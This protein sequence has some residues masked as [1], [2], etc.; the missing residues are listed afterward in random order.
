MSDEDD[1]HSSDICRTLARPNQPES[2]VTLMGEHYV[3]PSISSSNMG[4]LGEIVLTR[5]SRGLSKT[6]NKEV[7]YM[8]IQLKLKSKIQELEYGLIVTLTSALI[9]LSSRLLLRLKTKECDR[10]TENEKYWRTLYMDTMKSSSTNGNQSHRRPRSPSPI[11]F[12]SS[13]GAST[14]GR[15]P[16]SKKRRMEHYHSDHRYNPLAALLPNGTNPEVSEPEDDRDELVVQ[17]WH[18]TQF[19]SKNISAPEPHGIDAT[20]QPCARKYS[21]FEDGT[22]RSISKSQLDQFRS[23]MTTVFVTL[24]NDHRNLIK[25]FWRELSKGF[26]DAFWKELRIKFPFLRYCNNNWKGQKF[27][28]DHYRRWYVSSIEKGQD[29]SAGPKLEGDAEDVSTSPIERHKRV[30]TKLRPPPSFAVEIIRPFLGKTGTTSSQNHQDHSP[31]SPSP[32][33]RT[34]SGSPPSALH[35]SNIPSTLLPSDLGNPPVTTLDSP[36]GLP[37]EESALQ[38][39]LVAPLM[40]F[41]DSNTHQ[42]QEHS[43]MPSTLP[44]T[45]TLSPLHES[46]N[47]SEPP[48]ANNTNSDD[49]A[50]ASAAP[51]KN[52]VPAADDYTPPGSQAPESEASAPATATE[53]PQGAKGSK[54]LKLK[55]KLNK[56]VTALPTDAKKTTEPRALCK[57][58]WL[59]DPANKKYKS[60]DSKAQEKAFKESGHWKN[61]DKKNAQTKLVQMRSQ[62]WGRIVIQR[63]DAA[64]V[65]QRMS[66]GVLHGQ[67]VDEG[68]D[69][70]LAGIGRDW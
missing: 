29:A 66:F 37:S 14:R 36:D 59:N 22:G 13:P 34:D 42:D 49:R 23:Y 27:I 51:R 40:L 25:G 35:S 60:L 10:A 52:I 5:L 33:S 56:K 69:G 6:S 7:E 53:K 67:E 19:D 54:P 45:G 18:A 26:K 20:H 47:D 17:Y 46:H 70:V 43:A 16:P 21:Y 48:K 57:A 24:N 4:A 58:E 62:P 9:C 61:A 32:H 2:F 68:E 28:V 3:D 12:L 30:A 65:P 41:Q 55:L 31:V 8:H 63:N 39:L 44:Q 11:D 38:T 1:V 50:L 15:S 64:I